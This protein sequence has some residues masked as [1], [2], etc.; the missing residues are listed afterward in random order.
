MTPEEK[1]KNTQDRVNA[2]RVKCGLAPLD[3]TNPQQIKDKVAQEKR[4]NEMAKAEQNLVDA[5]RKFGQALDQKPATAYAEARAFVFAWNTAAQFSKTDKL[6][7]NRPDDP[8]VIAA[9][10]KCK[11]AW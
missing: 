8:E 7:G 3:F 10:R 9:L 2:S 6:K 5:A 1:K 11:G 4:Q